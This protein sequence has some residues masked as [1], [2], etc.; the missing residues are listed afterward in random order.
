MTLW[1]NQPWWYRLFH[2]NQRPTFRYAT[3]RLHDV[4]RKASIN[5]FQ[6]ALKRVMTTVPAI[7]APIVAQKSNDT[8]ESQNNE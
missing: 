7:A 4:H 6:N 8:E 2:I 5:A 1:N 3:D